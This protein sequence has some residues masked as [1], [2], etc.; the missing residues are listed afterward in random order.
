MYVLTYYG[1]QIS[2]NIQ[3]ELLRK[4]LRLWAAQSSFFERPWRLRN[5]ASAVNARFHENLGA[6]DVPR[7]LYWQLD[8]IIE[9]YQA[10]L[11]KAILANLEQLMFPRAY[12]SQQTLITVF[13]TAFIYLSVLESDTWTLKTWAKKSTAWKTNSRVSKNPVRTLQSD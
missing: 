10:S 1:L 5:G 12:R 8:F 11:E 9:E 6:S 4:V 13:T 3:G 7:M 2:L